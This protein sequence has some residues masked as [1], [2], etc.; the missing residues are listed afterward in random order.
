MTKYNVVSFRSV[1]NGTETE[2]NIH[3]VNETEQ[4]TE[5]EFRFRFSVFSAKT[6]YILFHF[7][8]LANE[9][10]NGMKMMYRQRNRTETKQLHSVAT[11]NV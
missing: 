2:C 11:G 3:F 4:K 5:W 1:R 6:R 7:V 8:S 10:E 9:T